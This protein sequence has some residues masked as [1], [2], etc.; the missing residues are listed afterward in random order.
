[1]SAGSPEQ[2]PP[3][4]DP[5]R[6]IVECC[7]AGAPAVVKLRDG[8]P[9]LRAAFAAFRNDEIEL[10]L[11]DDAAEPIADGAVCHVSFL[12]RGRPV[13]F[14]ATVLR[15]GQVGRHALLWVGQPAGITTESARAAFR[16]PGGETAPSVE[17]LG[18]DGV[19]RPAALLNLSLT[20]MYLRFPDARPT[21]MPD[22]VVEIVLHVEAEP[23]RLAGVVRRVEGA[24]VAFFFPDAV[25]ESA[26]NPVRR[27]M[28]LLEREWHARMRG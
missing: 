21:L 22:Q 25:S 6:I 27:V 20:G 28:A 11:L 9:G 2:A 8:D 1:V 26:Q 17:V 13:F 4:A 10:E 14:T 16:I 23:L 15:T 5:E 18:D 24:A 19:A 12:Y 3:G 7:A